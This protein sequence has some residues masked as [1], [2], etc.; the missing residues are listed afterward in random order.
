MEKIRKISILS[1]TAEGFRN[2]DEPTTWTFGP[3]TL[4]GGHNAVGKSGI[5]DA[6]AFGLTGAPFFG[7]RGLDELQHAMGQPMRVEIRFFD[8]DMRQHT[9]LRVRQNSEVTLSLDS[10]EMPQKRLAEQI[11]GK[12]FVLSLLN[13]SYFA[14]VLGA[15]GRGLLEQLV[16]APGHGAVL[17]QLSEHMRSILGEDSLLQPD[18][19]LKKKRAERKEMEKDLQYATG[20]KDANDRQ[21]AS[22]EAALGEKAQQLAQICAALKAY[23]KKRTTG[24]NR[25]ALEAKLKKLSTQFESLQQEPSEIAALRTARDQI[26]QETFSSELETQ[27]VKLERE[28]TQKTVQHKRISGLKKKLF[29]DARCPTCLREIDKAGEATIATAYDTALKQIVEQGRALRASY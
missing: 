2:F 3:V 15:G 1:V 25:S 21:R 5:A 4:V 24:V 9:L 27:R 18:T 10:I 22:L 29:A 20:Q 7:G 17:A 12:D 16:P 14:E 28:L 13:P 23:E 26:R 6:L 11:G 8:Q 19:Y